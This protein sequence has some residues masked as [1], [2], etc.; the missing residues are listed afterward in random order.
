MPTLCI[1]RRKSILIETI[2]HSR[3]PMDE[4]LFLRSRRAS[5]GLCWALRLRSRSLVLFVVVPLSTRLPLRFNFTGFRGIS[6][7]R[8]VLV[9]LLCPPALFFAS[10]FDGPWNYAP[11]GFASFRG[12]SSRRNADFLADDIAFRYIYGIYGA[13]QISISLGSK[14]RGYTRRHA[15]MRIPGSIF[16]M[17]PCDKDCP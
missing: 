16:Q 2:H 7:E 15:R 12:I 17:V 14:S 1:P 13:S 8:S 11:V 5:S 10:F 6:A 9:Y 4:L 3:R